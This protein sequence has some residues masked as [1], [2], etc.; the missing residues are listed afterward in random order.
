M[1]NGL[2]P[3]LSILVRFQGLHKKSGRT[4]G[5]VPLHARSDAVLSDA[6]QEAFPKPI[7]SAVG[8]AEGE[9]V[10]HPFRER[11]LLYPWVVTQ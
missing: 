11:I 9:R 2:R 5:S 10:V 7:V 6:F 4:H 1:G 3:K 8:S